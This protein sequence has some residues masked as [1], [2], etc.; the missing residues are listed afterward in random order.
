MVAQL[1]V[2]ALHKTQPSKLSGVIFREP[3]RTRCT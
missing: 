1:I 2:D 3:C